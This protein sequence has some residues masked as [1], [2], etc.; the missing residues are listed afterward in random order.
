MEKWYY[1]PQGKE[2]TEAQLARIADFLV[3]LIERK[4]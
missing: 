1:V 3:Y 4:S 2:L